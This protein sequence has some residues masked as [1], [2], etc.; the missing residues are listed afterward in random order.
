[1]KAKGNRS[2]TIGTQKTCHFDSRHFL[3][4]LWKEHAPK[5]LKSIPTCD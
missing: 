1:M 3:K 5:E 4:E 2:E